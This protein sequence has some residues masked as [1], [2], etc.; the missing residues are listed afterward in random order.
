MTKWI[1]GIGAALLIGALAVTS[2]AGPGRH[3][4]F[5][6]DRMMGYGYGHYRGFVSSEGAWGPGRC[7]RY[8]S[9]RNAPDDTPRYGRDSQRLKR[10]PGRAMRS[11]F[12]YGNTSE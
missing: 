5:F 4:G 8:A 2:F 7:G 10:G 1:I 11:P 9:Y 6:G 3:S 12:P